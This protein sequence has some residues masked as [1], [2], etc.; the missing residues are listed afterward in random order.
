VVSFL[1][2]AG[3]AEAAVPYLG[4][5]EAARVIGRNLHRT[6]DTGAVTGSLDTDCWRRARNK[7]SCHVSFEDYD[8]VFWCGTIH[9]TENRAYYNLAYRGM[10]EC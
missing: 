6:W 4:Y 10:G 7:I 1:A 9:V 3:P 2:F 8:G 5:G